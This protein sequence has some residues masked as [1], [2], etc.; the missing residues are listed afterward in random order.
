MKSLLRGLIVA[1]VVLV[2]AGVSSA[3]PKVVEGGVGVAVTPEVT[4]FKPANFGPGVGMGLSIVGLGLGLG[5]VGFAALGG[6]ARQPEQA[7]TIRGLTILLAALVEGA[8]IISLVL[9]LVAGL[10]G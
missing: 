9:C 3:Q 4:T 7:D 2:G 8:A 5:L 1:L 6:I 10:L